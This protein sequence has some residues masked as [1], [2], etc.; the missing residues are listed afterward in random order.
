MLL[1]SFAAVL[2]VAGARPTSKPSGQA[3]AIAGRRARGLAGRV[4]DNV[5]FESGKASEFVH[6]D[7]P[8]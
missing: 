6:D 1:L 4:G 8:P 5:R 2:A 7:L 3:T